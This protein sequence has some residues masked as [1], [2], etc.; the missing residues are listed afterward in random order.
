M[1]LRGKFS[2][3]IVRPEILAWHLIIKEGLKFLV[4]SKRKKK[5]ENRGIF[6][7]VKFLKSWPGT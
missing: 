5:N 3:F 4:M 7:G 1:K 2:G 6:D